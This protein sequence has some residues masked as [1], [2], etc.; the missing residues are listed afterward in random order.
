MW[1][2]VEGMLLTN[3]GCLAPSSA[4]RQMHALLLEAELKLLLG[5]DTHGYIVPDQYEGKQSFYMHT[6]IQTGC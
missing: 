6:F 2:A 1:V 3:L 5:P 4:L